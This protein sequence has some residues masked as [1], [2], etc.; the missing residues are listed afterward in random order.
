MPS[1]TLELEL[2]GVYSVD[3]PGF[4][5]WTDGTQE[6]GTYS[7]SSSGTSISITVNYGGSLPSSLEFRFNDASG[8]GGRTVE[9]QSVKINDKYVNVG[10]YLS[11]A[12]LVNGGNAT[13]DVAN[14]SFFYD[15]SEPSAGTFTPVTTTLTA[16]LDNHRDFSGADLILDGLAGNDRIFVGSGN[17][18]ITGGAGN[19]FIRGGGGNDLLYGA[20]DND[21]IF[22]E[23]GDDLLYGGAGND[24]I[25]GGADNDEI[26][27]NDGND[28]LHGNA[29]DDVITGGAGDDVITGG[30]GTNFLFGDAGDDQIIGD[31][32]VDTI[33]GGDDDD[34]LYGGGGDD[35]LDGGDGNDILVGD[36]GDD[37][38]NGNDGDDFLYGRADDDELNGNDGNDVLNGED[39]IDIL[40]GG[41]DNDVLIGG[42]GADTLNGGTGNDILHGSGLNVT[43][44]VTI[45][46]ANPS[47]S[48]SAQTNSFYQ[49]VNSTA[50]F[51]T[52]LAAAQAATLNGVGGHLV[53][54]TSAAENTL[55]DNLITGNIWLSATDSDVEGQWIWNGGAEDGLN[56][57]NGA[58]AGSAPASQYENWNGGEPN[59]FGGG[60]DNAEMR[61]D[62]LW[63]D[64]G[65]TLRYVIEWD[66]GLLSDDLAVDT[67]YGGTGND[68][69]YGYG[70]AD[71]LYGEDGNDV[72]IGGD[73]DDTL[74]GG[75][76]ADV[77][78]GQDGDDDLS[79]GAGTDY[80][81][82]GA[83]DDTIDGD[84]N[85]DF[86]YGNIGDD[87]L[88]GG[89]GADTIYAFDASVHTQ[90]NS[91]NA[92]NEIIFNENFSSGTGAFSY[93][94]GG[95][96]GTDGANVSVT[97]NRI[98]SDGDITASGA[99]RILVDGQNNNSFTNG[100]GSWDAS[101]SATSNLTNVQITF[102]YRHIHANANDTGEDSQ[103]W[104]EFDGTA[105]STGGGSTFLSEAY[106][107]AGTTN[108]GWVRVT[109]DLP[110]I[111]S[112]NTYNMSMGILHLGSSRANE[113]A[114]VRFDDIVM[115]AG[116]SYGSADTTAA[117]AD[118]GSTNTINGGNGNDTI[119]GSAGVN[120]LNGDDGDDTIYSGS[121]A[122]EVIFSDSFGGGVGSYTYADGVFGSAGSS[123]SYASGSHQAGD[124]SS[125]NGALQ[126]NL[127]GVNNS[128]IDDMSGAHQLNFTLTEAKN[129]LVL[130]FDY[131]FFDANVDGDPF[132]NGEDLQL[133]ADIDGTTYSN[134]ANAYFFELLG[135][136]A[137]DAYDSGWVTIS[138]DIG[139]LAAGAHTLSLGG[140]LTR[141]TFA[142]EEYILR[143]DDVSLVDTAILNVNTLAGGDGL[144]TLYGSS[145]RDVFLFEAAT[146]YNDL[147]AIENFGYTLDAIDL[148]DLLT[149]YNAA[150][151]DINDFVQL[152]EGGGNTTIS[153]DA[154]G[155]AGGA[156]FSNVA[157]VNGVTGMDLD[158]MEIDGTLIV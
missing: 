156:S 139:S 49:Y 103:V 77:L 50:N 98:T 51:T 54:I 157:I 41:A 104:F 47:V 58:A 69:I 105:Y 6:G 71:F 146:A 16:L 138:L 89:N 46:N 25:Q 38:L 110:D 135:T 44:I 42:D 55:I 143:F 3:M 108:T 59:D 102:S 43:E 19:D 73:G 27:G 145:G 125:G 20:A 39:G 26:H 67:L 30:A 45:L 151:D 75:A 31:S 74:S 124:G 8:E 1:Y 83:G 14:S 107:A 92:V 23:D 66:A 13:V 61:T 72:L 126:I 9:I 158:V 37:I 136:D 15:S 106:G 4:E 149:G 48:Y 154:N 90:G 36:T 11:S 109:I 137:Y 70:G 127:G 79:G 12:S 155:T 113:D 134:D 129:D 153:V 128:D 96:G 84:N 10:N 40:N 100:S 85:G 111:T 28:R 33:D 133:Y 86:I 5:I 18:T 60:E 132:D 130:T 117:D 53:T 115:T 7:I 147:D 123:N 95:F 62:G 112:G 87:V 150:T 35:F 93:S 121:V 80:L 65:G 76:N 78:H 97:G 94:D 56:F 81:Y 68:Y 64:N 91:L 32:G 22:G 131:R 21:R 17:D 57:W 82:G 116:T 148:S 122:D 52:A 101:Y 29:G 63:N 152:T 88:N 34:I 2:L 120:T 24:T 141:K 114:E 118:S 142:S 119:Y 99:L 144:D 140:L